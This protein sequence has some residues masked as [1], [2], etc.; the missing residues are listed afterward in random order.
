MA[1]AGKA[2]PHSHSFTP[3]S[4]RYAKIQHLSGGVGVGVMGAGN[5]RQPDDRLQSVCLIELL[6]KREKVEEVGGNCIL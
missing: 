3:R 6:R 2:A 5:L 4:R 1:G